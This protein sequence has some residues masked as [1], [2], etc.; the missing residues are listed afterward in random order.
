[1]KVG[2]ITGMGTVLKRKYDRKSENQGKNCIHSDD[3][4]IEN[5]NIQCWNIQVTCYHLTSGIK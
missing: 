2:D 3:N 4:I 1:M 5:Q